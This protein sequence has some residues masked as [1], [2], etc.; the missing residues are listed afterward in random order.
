MMD[1]KNITGII[2]AGGKSS[3][4]GSDKGLLM[5][6]DKPFIQHIIEVLNGLVSEILIVSNNTNHD[7]FE[8]KRIEDVIE[9]AGPLA[10]VYSGLKASKTD[11]NLV[12]SCD[13]PLITSH[14]LKT[15][16]NETDNK[17]DIVQLESQGRT[18]PLV[19]IY[20]TSCAELFYNLLQTGE[21]RLQFAVNHCKVKTI[22]LNTKYEEYVI[23]VNTPNELNKIINDY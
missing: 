1:Q 8:F 16:M 9:N 23:N 17:H 7:I 19:A 20:K 10:G 11:Y 2:L 18:M 13:V 12:L 14:I 4:M 6:N 3:R 21:R 22:V 15:L 5:L